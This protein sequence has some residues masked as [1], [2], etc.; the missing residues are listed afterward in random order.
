MRII[1]LYPNDLVLCFAVEGR[2]VRP[3]WEGGK[4]RG[5]KDIININRYAY[6]KMENGM[7]KFSNRMRNGRGSGNVIT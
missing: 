5:K 2:D 7:E 1:L 3:C 4:L 6:M